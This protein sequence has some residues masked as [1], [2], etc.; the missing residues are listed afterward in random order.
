[1]TSTSSQAACTAD[2]NSTQ[3]PSFESKAVDSVDG[4]VASCS[5]GIVPVHNSDANQDGGNCGEVAVAHRNELSPT[6]SMILDVP[7][8]PP[9]SAEEK[10]V[11]ADSD[12]EMEG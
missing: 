12:M 9:R 5:S 8:P 3:V 2:P 6:T 11:S 10:S 7:P 4:F 1:M